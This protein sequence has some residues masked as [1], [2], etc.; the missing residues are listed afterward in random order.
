M[1]IMDNAKDIA[2]L[3]KKYGDMELY[4]RIVDLRD[5]IFDLR[6]ENLK[7]KKDISCLEEEK[8]IKDRIIWEHP[9]YWLKNDKNKEGPYC[10]KCY[11]ENKKLIRLQNSSKGEWR[12]LVCRS[13]FKDSPYETS[14]PVYPRRSMDN[15]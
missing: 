8:D 13:F 6:E 1:G 7:L 11:D 4:Q 5:E 3:I 12:C 10:Q 15:I 2:K 9:Y 14:N